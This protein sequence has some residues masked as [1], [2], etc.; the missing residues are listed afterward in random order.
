MTLLA[1]DIG[2]G[3]Q[4]VLVYDPGRP[5]ENCTK[6]VLPAPTVVV[7]QRIREAAGRGEGIFLEGFTMG[8][9]GVVQ[10]VS[11]H[12]RKGLPVF[13][14]ETAALTIHDSLEKVRSLGIQVV[15][16]QPPGTTPVRT[17]DYMET[18]LRT[19]LGAFGLEYPR[20]LAFAV[21]DHGF[22]P[23]ESNRIHRFR[24]LGEVLDEGTWQVWALAKDPPLPTMT[25]MAALR[26]QVPGALVIDTGVAAILGT[27]CDPWVRE[28]AA[29]GITLVN[30]GNAHTFCVNLRGEE[31]CGIF[32]HHTASL[33]RDHLLSLIGKLRDG[34]LTNE[35]VFGEGGH[36]AR[37]HRPLAARHIAITGPNRK[38]LLPDGYQA[39]PFGDMMLTGCFGLVRAWEHLRGRV[40][41]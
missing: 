1:V 39:A 12:L 33:D 14:T 9:G 16:R 13:A 23:G 8:G 30:A 40:P 27:L 7:G 34:T 29:E 28:R 25:R 2:R 17:T 5:V 38:R 31:V 11:E 32:E 10:A 35:A 15:P 20:Y 4:D 22:A 24:I 6:M 41:P 18:G 21:Q 3:T 26:D 36:G 37:V 19:A